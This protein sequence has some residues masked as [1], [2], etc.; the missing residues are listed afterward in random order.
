MATFLI[1]GSWGG[2]KARL[3]DDGKRLY[4]GPRVLLRL[5]LGKMAMRLMTIWAVAVLVVALLGASV[6]AEAQSTGKRYRIGWLSLGD[7][8]PTTIKLTREPFLSV[9]KERGWAE[10][11][12]F[13]MEYRFAGASGDRLAQ[14][15]GELVQARVDVIVAANHSA[16]DAA[17]RAT[18]TI[19]IVM[20]VG[21]DPVG[22]GWV[23]S[24]A[25]PGGNVTGTASIITPE[26]AGKRLE[27]LRDALPQ[28]SRVGVLWWPDVRD[29][30]SLWQALQDSGTRL[31]IGLVSLPV[32]SVEDIN[33]AFP[34]ATR[35]QVEALLIQGDVFLFQNRQ[36]IVD[37]ADAYRLPASYAWTPYVDLGGFMSYGPAI[38]E[39]FRRAASYVDRILKGAK[40]AD[41]AVEQPTR[42]ELVVNIKT[43]R[44]LGLTIPP[45]LLLRADRLIE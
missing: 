33:G 29:P 2:Q 9:L 30:V 5:H 14:L 17:V 7:P 22:M 44:A 34:A 19:P 8:T 6:M 4:V 10:D 20:G 39:F 32:R 1:I 26:T 36:R 35:G 18:T 40:P 24:L 31:G 12:N 27:L 37:L 23:K 41:L 28:L 15:A 3:R 21:G 16:I 25:R 38:P 45:P 13:T 42:F 43:A 11:R